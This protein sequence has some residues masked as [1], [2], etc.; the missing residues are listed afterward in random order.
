MKVGLGAIALWAVVGVVACG[1]GDDGGGGSAAAGSSAAGGASSS[2]GASSGQGGDASGAS[3]GGASS[4]QGGDASS[5]GG[6]PACGQGMTPDDAI[7]LDA[8]GKGEGQLDLHSDKIWFKET[9]MLPKATGVVQT[10]QVLPGHADASECVVLR[11]EGQA[12]SDLGCDGTTRTLEGFEGAC[13]DLTTHTIDYSCASGTI[14][15]LL[16]VQAA[17]D[18]GEMLPPGC[19]SV[20]A[21]V[22]VE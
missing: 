14:D 20:Q 6:A 18:V 3:A 21:T 4:G 19:E 22:S 12:F 5:A 15:V 10:S 7:P 9:L 17:V 1:S 16:L 8:N 13:C 2:A 11:C